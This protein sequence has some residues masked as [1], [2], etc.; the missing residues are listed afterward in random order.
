M[1]EDG[2]SQLTDDS[3]AS[4]PTT[5]QSFADISSSGLRRSKRKRTLLSRFT[6]GLFLTACA[7]L[8]TTAYASQTAYHNFLSGYDDYLD[9][10][11]DGTSNSTSILGQIYLSGKI[12]NKTYTLKEMLQQPDRVEFEKAMYEEVKAMFKNGI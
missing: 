4:K 9:L 11:F 2:T 8:T 12:D 7:F 6:Y 3:L 1:R 5:T 10:N